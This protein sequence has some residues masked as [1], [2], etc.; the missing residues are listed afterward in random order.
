MSF[1]E[2]PEP[3]PASKP[4]YDLGN[5]T[6]P[7]STDSY[8]ALEWFN[9]G[10][11][12]VYGFN[13]AAAAQCFEQALAHDKE[14]VAAYWGLAYASG[15]NYNKPWEV[16]D[17][18]DIK[19]TVAKCHWAVEEGLKRRDSG[20]SVVEVALLEAIGKRF[21]TDRDTRTHQ[22]WNVAYADAMVE[23]YAKFKDD[24]DVAAL[25][26]DA[27]MNLTPWALWDISTGQPAKKSRTVEVKEI[28][29]T[30]LATP[31]GHN[32]IGLL[33]LYIHYIEMSP[34]PELGL[35]PG[36]RLRKLSPDGGHLT[37]MPS[38]IDVLVGEYRRAI[39]SNWEAVVADEKY[40]KESGDLAFYTFYRLHDYHTI[41]YAAMH[42]GQFFE[43]IRAVDGMENSLVPEVL[44]VES[45][46]MADWLEYFLSVRPHVLVRFGKW[47]EILATPLPED[48]HLYC[49]LTA[50]L[51]YAKGIACAV[52][53]K[54][55][56]AREQQRLYEDAI[57][58]VP[59]SRMMY[60][61]TCHD[62][63]AVGEPMLEGEIAYRLGDYTSAFEALREA[64]K[65]YDNLVYA[66]P[67][68]WM[69]PI[70]HALAAL[71]L[72]QHQVEE[73]TSVYAEDL[74]ISGTLPRACQHPGNVWALHGYHECLRRLGKERSR[75]ANVIQKQLAV[76]LAI[77]DVKVE[78]SCYCVTSSTKKTKATSNSNGVADT[79]GHVDGEVHGDND[80]STCCKA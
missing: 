8:D 28:L 76:A 75:E 54:I 49:T 52:T 62:I 60:P 61:N 68:G 2:L 42:C 71:L 69:Q 35:V 73:A 20:V 58:R 24:V 23:V 37:H 29:D 10:L 7:A 44:R 15:P 22:E 51:H 34:T 55:P 33:H 48:Q 72:E 14:C 17:E 65:L 46:P 78:S 32:H 25:T 64:V 45:P 74:G 26:A 18:A 9:R 3:I 4:Y 11:R 70:R 27:L 6:R 31:A 67:W 66:E 38:H 40:R 56:E 77:V 39:A 50:T 79:D 1:D 5:L 41:V 47:D 59:A 63:L 53:G 57:K 30:A 21:P 19:R 16:F 13:H 36:D 43:A 12:W 80:V